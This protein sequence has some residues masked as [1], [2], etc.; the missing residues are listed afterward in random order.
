MLEQV[1]KHSSVD[2]E[3]SC[4]GDLEVDE[5]HTIED[6]GIVLGE[7]FAKALGNKKGIDRYG[8]LIPM[9]E[10]SS[11]ATLD[12]SG[13]SFC[14]FDCEFKKEYLGEMPTEMISH[15]FKSF[16]EGAKCTLQIQV[17]GENDHHKAEAAFKSLAKVLEQ[18][19]K[20]NPNKVSIPSSKGIL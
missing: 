6:C 16:A 11:Y 5:H 20:R 14:L 15:F 13:R 12:F 17:K 8:F 1:S 2:I 4:K 10:S 3:L 9:D 18:A 19:V 7:A